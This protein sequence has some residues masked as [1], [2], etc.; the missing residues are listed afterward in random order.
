MSRVG[1]AF[2]FSRLGRVLI[3]RLLGCAADCGGRN[4]LM[5]ASETLEIAA[6]SPHGWIVIAATL[7]LPRNE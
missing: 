5:K 7:T 1:F 6:E 3:T 2:A 4:Q